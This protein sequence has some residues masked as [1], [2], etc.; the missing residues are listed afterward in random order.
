MFLYTRPLSC[1]DGI[2]TVVLE[3]MLQRTRHDPSGEIKT[4]ETQPKLEEICRL[5]QC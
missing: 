1:C 5:C 2:D 4:L 3:I